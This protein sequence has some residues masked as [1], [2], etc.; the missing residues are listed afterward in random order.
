ML[1]SETIQSIIHQ[2]NRPAFSQ[3][4]RHLEFRIAV[5][6]VWILWCSRW[7]HYWHY[8]II[9][10]SY[11]IIRNRWIKHNE[12]PKCC[13][14]FCLSRNG[15][16]WFALKSVVRLFLFGIS[17]WLE[18]FVAAEF[19]VLESGLRL[20]DSSFF[21]CFS[22]FSVLLFSFFFV[23]FFCKFFSEKIE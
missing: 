12:K 22:F 20:Q 18:D 23:F 17:G 7:F 9:I 8:S 11:F 3:C 1:D 6:A 2:S 5:E 14:Y 15:V 4:L 13:C 16:D 21:F 19:V 10:V